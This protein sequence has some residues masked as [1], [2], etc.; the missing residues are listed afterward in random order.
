VSPIPEPL[1]T[2]DIVASSLSRNETLLNKLKEKLSDMR[3]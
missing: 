1:R 2:S 3:V